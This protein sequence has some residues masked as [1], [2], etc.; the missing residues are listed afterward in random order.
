MFIEQS[1]LVLKNES[2][3]DISMFGFF[4][5]NKPT[6]ILRVRESIMAQGKSDEDWWYFSLKDPNDFDWFIDQTG[7]E[8][9]YFAAI[10]DPILEKIKKRFSCRWVLSC[11]RFYLPNEILLP[12]IELPISRLTPNDAKQIYCNSNYKTFTSEKY[13]SE[14]I[15]NGPG[16]GFF[17]KSTLVGWVLTHDDGALGALHVLD[18]YRRKGIAKALLV[19]I[20]KKVRSNGL[21]PYTYVETS[22]GKSMS[23]VKSLGF[24]PDR[25]IHWVCIER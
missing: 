3:A 13:I 8:D 22:N 10:E 7:F 16:S 17:D 12:E 25:P 19:D 5:K 6:K 18:Q 21:T 23:L 1:E 9:C 20:I 14:Q 24:I 15:Q 2:I 11:Q 4:S